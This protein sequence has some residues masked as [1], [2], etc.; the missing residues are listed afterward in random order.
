MDGK[1]RAAESLAFAEEW[2]RFAADPTD[3][4]SMSSRGDLLDR[5]VLSWL[6]RR[7]HGSGARLHDTRLL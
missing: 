7:G 2:Q 4:E 1:V 3:I 6:V 5:P